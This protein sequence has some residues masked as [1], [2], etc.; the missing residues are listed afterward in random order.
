[1]PPALYA[2]TKMRQLTITQTIDADPTAHWAL[3][4]DDNYDR[5]QDLEGLHYPSYEL[6]ERS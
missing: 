5:E 3:Y 2:P 6:V 1:M 4:L